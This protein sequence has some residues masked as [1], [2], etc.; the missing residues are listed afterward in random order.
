MHAFII[1][2]A[3]PWGGFP[4]CVMRGAPLSPDANHPAGLFGHGGCAEDALDARGRWL[5]PARLR[6]DPRHGRGLGR[7]PDG[8]GDGMEWLLIFVIPRWAWRRRAA[9]TPAHATSPRRQTCDPEAGPASGSVHGRGQ[10]WRSRAAEIRTQSDMLDEV[11]RR[12]MLAIAASYERLA[13][14]AA[15]RAKEAK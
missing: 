9:E 5:H 14:R 8:L 12:M 2:A 1:I 13:E 6:P 10:Y 7:P 3:T 4:P 15:R 11:S